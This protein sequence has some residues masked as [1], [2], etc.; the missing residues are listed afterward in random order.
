MRAEGVGKVVPGFELEGE[1]G[2]WGGYLFRYHEA[3]TC[4]V[5]S[6][7][8]MDRLE[9]EEALDEGTTPYRWLSWTSWPVPDQYI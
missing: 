7:L 5:S 8:A 3:G 1:V 9:I 6:M 2:R 4:V